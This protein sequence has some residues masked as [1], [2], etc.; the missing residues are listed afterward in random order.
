MLAAA[1]AAFESGDTRWALELADALLATGDHDKEARLLRVAGLER[2]AVQEISAN[3]RAYYLTQ[4]RETE[5]FKIPAFDSKNA[6]DSLLSAL[7][8]ANYMYAMTVK[9]D[10]EKALDVDR[11]VAFR[12]PDKQLAYTLHVRRGV[13]ELSPRIE[14]R[15]DITVTTDSMVWKRILAGKRNLLAAYA[16]GELKIQGSSVELAR[17]LLLF[18]P[19]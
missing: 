15:P 2:L 14:E 19:D 17:F 7:P 3:G 5:G 6:L 13:A 11:K 16:V 10:A 9:L 1:H 4:A 18:R 8:I 12:F